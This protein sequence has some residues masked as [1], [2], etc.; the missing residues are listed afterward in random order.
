MHKV[1]LHIAVSKRNFVKSKDQAELSL[2]ISS[3]P[4]E[5]RNKKQTQTKYPYL[6]LT[7]ETW[8]KE[9]PIA[10]FL[11][12]HILTLL[13]FFR[14]AVG[15]YHDCWKELLT[16]KLA[17]LQSSPWKQAILK[18]MS[19]GAQSSL[20]LFRNCVWLQKAALN[21][22]IFHCNAFL[23]NIKVFWGIWFWKSKYFEILNL[24]I[25]KKYFISYHIC[26]PSSPMVDY[27]VVLSIDS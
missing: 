21:I 1:K 9:C 24:S 15:C 10:E 4:K 19:Q 17:K 6:F 25:W 7:L 8:K 13:G 18:S 3:I 23:Q 20:F 12:S 26:I 11:S 5:T 22:N 27:S 16:C 14:P 2:N